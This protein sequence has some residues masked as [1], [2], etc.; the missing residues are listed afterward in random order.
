MN[1]YKL[2]TLTFIQL[3]SLV[4]ENVSVVGSTEFLQLPNTC[5]PNDTPRL[6]MYCLELKAGEPDKL[7]RNI[8]DELSSYY[9]ELVTVEHQCQW[10][11]STNIT[12]EARNRIGADF[13]CS[14]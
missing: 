11:N 10:I 4:A 5:A 13:N 1:L 2:C 12:N 9:S 6:H 8:T 14:F 3:N 7:S